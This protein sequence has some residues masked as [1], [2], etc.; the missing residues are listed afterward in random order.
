[1]CDVPGLLENPRLY[2]LSQS[3]TML[4]AF[5]SGSFCPHAIHPTFPIHLGGK[6]VEV[7]VEVVYAPLNYNLL[8]GHNFSY[9]ITV[10]ISSVLCTLCFPHDGKIMMID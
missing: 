5:N 7:D 10:I 4:T 6:T 9:P 2:D 1:M 3:P 8:L